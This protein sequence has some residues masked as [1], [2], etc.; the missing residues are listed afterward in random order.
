MLPLY[1]VIVVILIVLL[2]VLAVAYY[3][4]W[5]RIREVPP[6]EGVVLFL[7]PEFDLATRYGHFWLS[8][9]IPYATERGWEVVDLEGDSVTPDGFLAAL[10][11]SA[12]ILIHGCSHGN[13]TTFTGQNAVPLLVAC[14]ND[15]LMSER[16]VYLLSCIT[17]KELGP[18]MVDKGCRGYLGYTEE[19]TW[20]VDES[21]AVEEDPYAM[22]FG[23]CSNAVARAL[24]DGRSVVDAHAVGVDNFNAEIERWS[25]VDDPAAGAVVQWL[26]HDRDCFIVLGMGAPVPPIAAVSP[27]PFIEGPVTV[28]LMGL[29]VALI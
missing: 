2:V 10:A 26:L 20:C 5:R 27:M 23:D 13:A 3:M 4:V 1:I 7:R 12:P 6:R 8:Q 29:V 19:F 22:P 21:Y 15:D 25:T 28:G 17:G 14:L 16:F 18:S 9:L 24:L 11:S